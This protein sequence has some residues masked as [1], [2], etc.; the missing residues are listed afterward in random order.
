MRYDHRH[1]PAQPPTPAPDAFEVHRVPVADGLSLAF[2]REG[3]GGMP[4]LLIHGYPETKRIWWRNIAPLA[5]AGFE[6]IAV[7]LQGVG[8]SDIPRPTTSRHRHLRQGPARWCTTSSATTP[9][10]WRPAT[11]AAWWSP[12][13]S[14]LP[15]F[16]ERL[17]IFNTVPPWA[18]DAYAEA[19]AGLR[20]LQRLQRRADRRLPRLRGARP[21]E[22]AA[23]LGTD[24]AADGGWP[25]CTR[26]GCGR[27]PARSR[28][29][30]STS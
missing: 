11:S 12:T 28:P 4:L 8:D 1:R 16:V 7:D 20:D 27:R 5:A 30:T 3:V 18:M 22:L 26:A 2:V 21:D 15:D 10:R 29:T 13:W 17:C 19:G 24:A 14:T 25:G 23:M 9:V 6:V